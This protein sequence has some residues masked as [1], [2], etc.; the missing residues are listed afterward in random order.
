MAEG[1][2]P[3]PLPRFY[4]FSRQGTATQCFTIHKVVIPARIALAASSFAGKRSDSAELRDNLVETV[5]VAL[6]TA[7]LQDRLASTEHAP[8]KVAPPPGLPPGSPALEVRR[9]CQLSYEGIEK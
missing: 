2:L 8:P 3:K 1:I 9:S 7:C 4:L 5:R 6:T